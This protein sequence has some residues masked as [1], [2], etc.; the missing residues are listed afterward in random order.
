MQGDFISQEDLEELLRERHEPAISVYLPME[1]RGPD[2]RGNPI[3]LKNALAEIESEL[4]EEGW[5]APDVEALLAAPRKMLQDTPYWQHQREGLA[6]FLAPDFLHHY[7]LALSFEPQTIINTRFFVKPILPY[8]SAGGHYYVV[9]VSQQ[10]VRLLRATRHTVEEVPLGDEIP[11]SLAEALEYDDPE[12]HLNAHTVTAGG[13]GRQGG[14]PEVTHHGHGSIDDAADERLRRFL[15]KVS[16][17]LQKRLPGERAPLV[18]AAVDYLHP[19]FAEAHHS[20]ELYLLQQGIHGNPEHDES[21]QLHKQS[22]ELVAPVFATQ[23]E[24]ARSRYHNMA[25][26]EQAS[27][28][29][30]EIVLGA[31]QG[32]VDSL[33]VATDQQRW[34][35]YDEANHRIALHDEQQTGDDE[36]LDFAAVHT[37]V[38]GGTVYAVSHEAVPA[39]AVA[40]AIFR[41]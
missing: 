40:A 21:A 4:K 38:N 34:G 30:E 7:R 20:N 11:A 6:L 19:L 25:G 27:A 9:A 1:Q 2:V 3:R 14:R 12:E 22:W 28:D 10:Q 35:H 23:E 13:P 39:D 36:L 41:Y 18:L 8:F 24:Q 15:R 31:V 33:F 16:A 29:L 37:L 17:G 32:R 5:R 26:T